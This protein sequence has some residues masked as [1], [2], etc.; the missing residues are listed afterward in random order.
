MWNKFQ[1][2][3]VDREKRQGTEEEREEEGEMDEL[4]VRRRTEVRVNEDTDILL[5]SQTFPILLATR[6]LS[7]QRSNFK[8]NPRRCPLHRT[9]SHIRLRSLPLLLYRFSRLRLALPVL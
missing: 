3:G 1:T 8:P 4:E 9:S 5:F 2:A 7:A 6:K